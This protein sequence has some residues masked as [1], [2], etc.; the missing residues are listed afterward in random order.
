M[1][2]K[3]HYEVIPDTDDKIFIKHVKLSVDWNDYKTLIYIFL[4]LSLIIWFFLSIFGL[5]VG[6][7]IMLKHIP[8]III[9]LGI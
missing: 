5:V 8:E 1:E 4:L 2:S 6:C 3:Y 7:G 9:W